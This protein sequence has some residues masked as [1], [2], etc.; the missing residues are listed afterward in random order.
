MRRPLL[1]LAVA[2][3][4][5]IALAD[6][7]GLP[8][9]PAWLAAGALTGL[10]GL[11][12]W[13][14]LGGP[15]RFLAWAG[16]CLCLGL[17]RG[18]LPDPPAG[19]PGDEP[20]VLM[21][22]AR[23][24]LVRAPGGLRLEL[25]AE[26]VRD[27]AGGL[28]PW[29]GGVRL[30]LRSEADAQAP[31][32]R[33]DVQG[34]DCPLVLPGDR[35]RA[36]VRLHRPRG[37]R[38]F[39]LPDPVLAQRRRGIEWVGSVRGCQNLV[40]ELTPPP[41]SARRLAARARAA[42]QALI[43][44]RPAPPEARGVLAALTVGDSGSVSPELRQAFAA[45][46]LSHLLAVSGLHLGCVALGL[47]LLLRMLLLRIPGLALRLDVR[48]LAAGLC[49]P[50]VG[51]YVLLTG[52]QAPAMRAGVMVAAFLLA[53]L[54]RRRADPLQT[55]S[56][57]ALVLLGL[58]PQAL[59]TASFQLSFAA[60]LG[61]ILAAP[62]MCAWLGAPLGQPPVGLLR[63]ARARLIQSFAVSL[64]AGLATAP[65]V[66][67]LFGQA[68]WLGVLAN[69]VAVPLA[70]WLIVPAGLLAALLLPLS[71]VVAGWAADL[72]LALAGLLAELAGALAAL[73]GVAVTF[74]PWS[75][76]TAALAFGLLGGLLGAWR[77][78]GRPRASRWLA[79]LS[80]AGLLI[81]LGWDGLAPRR[82]GQLEVIALDVGQGDA[83]LA[84]L[85]SGLTLL[86]DGGRGPD[87]PGGYDPSER[88]LLPAL[89]ALGI[90]R[91][92]AVVA[93]HAHPDH[94]GGLTRAIRELRPA[95]VWLPPPIPDAQE[96]EDAAAR[97]ALGEAAR[98]VGAELRE[99]VAGEIPWE[100]EGERV[101]VLWPPREGAEALGENE[102]SLVLRLEGAGR[103]VLLTGDLEREGEK[104]L[105]TA[106]GDLGA[107]VLKVGHH[108]SFHASASNFLAAV[109]PRFALVSAGA[110]NPY[111][112]PHPSALERL[113]R[114]GARIL[115]TDRVGAVRLR[116]AGEDWKVECVLPCPQ[117]KAGGD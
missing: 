86:V 95:A 111:G 79:G 38:N 40:L 109:R 24:G 78:A 21:G 100:R 34:A 36:L 73:P 9:W 4:A 11:L 20:E 18:P 98:E 103:R 69:L 53:E 87:E 42:V 48:R 71:G 57:A 54:L 58:W 22:V 97:R 106:G 26:A 8:A 30:S 37:A 17:A 51:F 25:E 112:L 27:L 49:L 15:L 28:R 82:T 93:S 23:S 114:I 64:V 70:A 105:V 66:A 104:A 55:L 76:L 45:S 83:L 68:S 116:T 43:E 77:G 47:Y 52:A 94:T 72:G 6:A 102:R 84:R 60:A 10:A 56:A 65:L 29:S 67:H 81:G 115:R 96:E 88:V 91:L 99:L 117:S 75:W 62:P 13:R 107:E 1:A 90:R 50:A 7:S 80:A 108:G 2:F 12:A 61:L 74:V 14:R 31:D 46:G 41:I 89:G 32:V 35:L 113:R 19:E 33:G 63:R 5:G 92:D 85:P 101:V 44:S 3:A 39:G 59:C 16:A 110:G